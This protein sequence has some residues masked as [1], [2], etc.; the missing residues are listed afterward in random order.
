MTTAIGKIQSVKVFDESKKGEIKLCTGANQFLTLK[1]SN[2]HDSVFCG[3][4][5]LA[6]A[7]VAFSDPATTQ[8]GV[9]PNIHVEYNASDM[10]IDEMEFHWH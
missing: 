5:A 3:M 7:A 1:L 6:F 2:D 4:V 10:E 8:P 9:P